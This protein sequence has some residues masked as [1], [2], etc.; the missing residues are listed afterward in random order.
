MTIAWIK[1]ICAVC[2]GALFAIVIVPAEAAD[3]K[4]MVPG[5]IFAGMNALAQSFSTE[6]LPAFKAVLIGGT[7]GT[8]Q[9]NVAAGMPAD[10]VI[11]PAADMDALEKAGG[12][13]LGS[14]VA[15]GRVGFGLAVRTGAPH[16]D[17][18]TPERFR[19][20]L[21]AAKSV[22]YN[23]PAI[24]SLGGVVIAQILARPEFAGVKAAPSGGARA[25]KDGNAEIALQ[26]LSELIGRDGV[27]LV[28]L[29]PT[30]LDAHMEFAA[31]IL[32]HG[33]EPAGAAQF[34]RYITRPEATSVWK[35][36]GVDR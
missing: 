34:L 29:L 8:I 27:E 24:G 18:S 26:S 22:S 35:V 1:R 12:I 20:V 33:T 10:I 13:Q 4:I 5:P 16:P 6:N 9:K 32:S 28:G 36:Y 11:L 31:A 17:I 30:Y 14:R 15:M 3:V 19:A 21:L 2:I 25:V 7:V 23:D